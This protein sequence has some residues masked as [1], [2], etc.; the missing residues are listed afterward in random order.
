M[1]ERPW[2]QDNIWSNFLKFNYT[3]I[4]TR[5]WPLCL[6]I[7]ALV[8]VVSMFFLRK[9]LRDKKLYEGS[10]SDKVYVF[11]YKKAS[12][13]IALLAVMAGI[14]F[15]EVY[16]LTLENSLF[17]N[18]DLMAINTTRTMRYGLVASFDYIRVIPLG[19]W[20]LSSL[21]AITQNIIIIKIFVLFQTMLAAWALSAF[22]NYIPVARKLW[23]IAILLVMPTLLQTAN[24]IFP[25]RDMIIAL[26][27]GLI[28]ARKYCRTHQIRWAAAFLLFVNIAF[29]TKETCIIFYFGIVLTSLIYNI[30]A[31]KIVMKSL[32]K[33]WKIIQIMPLEFLLG[34]SLLGY[35]VIFS[36][37]QN[38]TNFYLSANTQTLMQQLETYRLELILMGLAMGIA[39]Y[40][41]IKFYS[42]KNNPMFRSGL[43]VGAVCTAIMVVAVFKLS[44]ST[45]HLAGKSYYMLTSTIFVLAYIFEYLKSK[46]TVGILC[47]ILLIYSILTDIAFHQQNKGIYYREV[48]EYMAEHTVPKSVNHLFVLEGPYVTKTLWQ[49][50]IETWSTS[51][52]YYFNDRIFVIKSDVHYLD[53]S[54]VQKL[55]VFN[56]I[57]LIYFPLVP[58]P[59]PVKGDWLV[60]NKENQTTKAINLRQEYSG[61][62]VYE[63][64]LFEV[65][66][67]KQ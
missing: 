55:R 21:Y 20:Y 24:I 13:W 65:Y 30:V 28:F 17:E 31:Q 22:F 12:D 11:D 53:R 16:I 50:I 33:P 15:T 43:L 47:A 34:L 66:A 52:R 10:F 39:I 44:P 38:G 7:I 64:A 49:W 59:Q 36:M 61:K 3:Y 57:P 1:F 58:Q 25:E 9:F 23:M 4:S 8:L 45:P 37:M 48:A 56:N 42:E 35:T 32:L 6:G 26:M 29:Y 18:Y 41:L 40:R 63:N 14:V 51:Y 67:P 5:Q 2:L 60:I 62:L 46:K 19:S 27:L 54:I